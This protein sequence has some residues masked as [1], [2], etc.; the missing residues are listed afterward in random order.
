MLYGICI[1]Y[2]F[3]FCYVFV[4]TYIWIFTN[5]KDEGNIVASTYCWWV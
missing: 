1:L 4:Y 2:L 3:F 5:V